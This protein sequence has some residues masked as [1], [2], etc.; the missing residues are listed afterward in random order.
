MPAATATTLSGEEHADV[1]HADVR[2]GLWS[3]SSPS[4]FQCLA[5]G[6]GPPSC[7]RCPSSDWP[8]LSLSSPLLHTLHL[9]TASGKLKPT[10]SP[11]DLYYCG[12]IVATNAV[13]GKPSPAITWPRHTL[14]QLPASVNVVP[15][16]WKDRV[17]HIG[18]NPL[19]LLT[20]VS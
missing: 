9:P 12:C 11:R 5:D 19:S 14:F 1:T 6:S 10:S 3:D 18:F 20:A 7:R 13:P 15:A 8:A 4:H 2:L 16:S 17:P